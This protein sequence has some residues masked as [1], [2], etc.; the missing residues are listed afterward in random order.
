MINHFT[1]YCQT[2]S[3]VEELIVKDFKDKILLIKNRNSPFYEL[4]L[5][6]EDSF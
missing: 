2:F 4:R 6:Y 3:S 1:L 5:N